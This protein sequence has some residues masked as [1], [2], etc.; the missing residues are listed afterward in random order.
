MSFKVNKVN[1]MTIQI[2]FKGK[3][4]DERTREIQDLEPSRISKQFYITTQ[5]TPDQFHLN[6]CHPWRI[7]NVKSILCVIHD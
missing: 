1:N 5:K 2:P 7:G 6:I 3:K 4:K